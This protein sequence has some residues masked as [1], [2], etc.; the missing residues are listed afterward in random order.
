MKKTIL[1]VVLILSTFGIANAQ[2]KKMPDDFYKPNTTIPDISN[3]EIENLIK[4]KL[5]KYLKSIKKI[6]IVDVSVSGNG[7]R[8]FLV[9]NNYDLPLKKEVRGERIMV[10]YK[11]TDTN[12]MCYLVDEIYLFREYEGGGS[13]G[14]P[15]LG[16]FGYQKASCD[17][18]V[19]K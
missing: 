8:W 17:I 12:G 6:K 3:S 1:S 14:K 15:K 18:P 2:L 9:K 7:P 16:R 5:G 13:Y 10:Y 19:S 4:K 11:S